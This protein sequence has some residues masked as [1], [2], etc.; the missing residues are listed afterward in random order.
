VAVLLDPGAAQATVQSIWDHLPKE[1]EVET[2]AGVTINAANL[3][4]PAHAYYT[5]TG[6]LTTP[7]CSEPVTW[8]VL[9]TPGTV[10]PSEV[11]TFST[12]YPMNARPIQPLGD[13]VIKV[14]K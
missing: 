12:I 1:K 7:P 13:R 6:S 11:E 14:S 10:S 2:D 8:F 5:F 9:K 3:L 4:P